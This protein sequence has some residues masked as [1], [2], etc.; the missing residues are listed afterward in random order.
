M[1]EKNLV[2]TVEN[3]NSPVL[4][5]VPHGGIKNHQGSW[6][7]L[8]F[9]KRI[10]SDKEEKNYA[11]GEKI[12]LGGDNQ[13][14]H[15]VSDILKNYKANAVVGLLPRCFVDYNRFVPRIAYSDKKIKPFYD[16]YHNSISEIL[17]NLIS[18]YENVFLFDFHGFGHQP[19]KGTEFDIILG[20]NNQSSPQGT[21][22][23]LYKYFK[24]RN[25]NVFCAGMDDLPKESEMYKGDTTNLRYHR[26]YCVE[27][28][29]VEVSSK[30]RSSKIIDSH[31]YGQKIAKDFAEFFK[32]LEKSHSKIME[33]DV[34]NRR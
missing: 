21:D 31:I 34:M 17:D 7:D 5:T 8:F 23:L 16:E 15:I 22:K 28:M 6:F 29:L 1:K 30:F 12:V 32:K 33:A 3:Y 20:T 14:M 19:L 13:I 24:K 26:F 27:A 2:L 4:I 18:K 25:Y 9:N 10:K 11:D